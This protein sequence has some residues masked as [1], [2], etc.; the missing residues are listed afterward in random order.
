MSWYA[1]WQYQGFNSLRPSDAYMRRWQSH[2]WPAPSHYLNQWW[3]IV[4]WTF[5]NKLQGNSNRNY[6]NFIQENVFE[7]VVCKIA[8]ILSR[9]QCVLMLFYPG[10]CYHTASGSQGHGRV[11][12][13]LGII[14]GGG[15]TLRLWAPRSIL[16]SS[17]WSNSLNTGNHLAASTRRHVLMFLPYKKWYVLTI[18]KSIY[19]SQCRSL[20]TG[21]PRHDGH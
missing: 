10:V 13:T 20:N 17:T 8:A 3:D 14:V 2:H 6:N 18:Q 19:H 11:V 5:R 15:V 7:Y 9:S 16:G 21:R 1:R 4:N 12:R